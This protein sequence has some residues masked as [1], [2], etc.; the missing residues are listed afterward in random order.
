M[1]EGSGVSIYSILYAA[2]RPADPVKSCLCFLLRRFLPRASYVDISF[3]A[4]K[5]RIAV[6]GASRFRR[7]L[8]ARLRRDVLKI[9]VGSGEFWKSSEKGRKGGRR[10][11]DSI[12]GPLDVCGL[13]PRVGGLK[14]PHS[15]V[16]GQNASKTRTP[17]QQVRQKHVPLGRKSCSKRQK[18]VPLG[19]KCVKNA[20]P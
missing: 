16:R 12:S 8:T 4:P 18:R 9:L 19:K 2:R 3:C 10:R 20:Y 1:L 7:S 14:R 17:K 6:I 5:G 11:G 13:G 15:E